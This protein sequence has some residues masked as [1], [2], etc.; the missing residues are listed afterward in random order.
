MGPSQHE[1]EDL[2]GNTLPRRLIRNLPNN[3]QGGDQRRCAD[4]DEEA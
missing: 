1:N 2:K 4:R 3:Q